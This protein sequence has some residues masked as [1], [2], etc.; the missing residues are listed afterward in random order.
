MR[1]SRS[2]WKRHPRKKRKAHS[3]SRPRRS[4]SRRRT[5]NP[6]CGLLDPGSVSSIRIDGLH[7]PREA[8]LFRQ[9]SSFECDQG[10]QDVGDLRKRS[11]TA[12]RRRSSD[13]SARRQVV[14]ISGNALPRR[15]Q[16]NLA[17]DDQRRWKPALSS[18]SGNLCYNFLRH[19]LILINV[20][21]QIN[22]AR[23]MKI[24][25]Y[26]WFIVSWIAIFVFIRLKSEQ[27]NMLR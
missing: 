12:A 14:R 2:N 10:A 17:G 6:R 11:S 16:T 9:R 22:I 26:T 5:R 1:Q 15:S 23:L 8:I 19:W 24:L 25:P 21:M 18:S 20:Q 7:D 27:N 4:S 3:W 13:A